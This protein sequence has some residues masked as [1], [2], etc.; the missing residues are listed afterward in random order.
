MSDTT[1][2]HSLDAVRGFALLAG[3]ALHATIAF[4]PGMREGNFPISDDSQSIG[5]SAV[6]FVIHI[7]RMSLFFAIAGF[8]AHV[9]LVRVGVVGLIKNRLRRI[10]LP[11]PASLLV[12]GPM[13]IPAFL[14]AKS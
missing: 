14:L 7:F 8:F 9:L 10:A 1:R 13:M 6:F 12:V 11:L 5:L 4:L 2:Y 3:I